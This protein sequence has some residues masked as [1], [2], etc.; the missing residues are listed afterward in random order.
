MFHKTY[1]QKVR[2]KTES[3]DC[4]VYEAKTTVRCIIGAKILFTSEVFSDFNSCEIS[5]SYVYEIH[6]TCTCS[7][8]K[9][10]HVERKN[11]VHVHAYRGTFDCK[12]SMNITKFTCTYDDNISRALRTR[13]VGVRAVSIAETT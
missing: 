5:L 2:F 1:I 9:L 11:H 4:N 13:H 12:R 8:Q 6:C 3:K 7:R 10:H